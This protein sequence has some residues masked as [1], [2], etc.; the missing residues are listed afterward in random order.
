MCWLSPRSGKCW[1]ES[2][3][4]VNV[5][6]VAGASRRAQELP[7]TYPETL[8]QSPAACQ[9]CRPSPL[10]GPQQTPP[11][12]HMVRAGRYGRGACG[13]PYNCAKCFAHRS[14]IVISPIFPTIGVCH[15]II[16][17]FAPVIGTCVLMINVV[18][19]VCTF[20]MCVLSQSI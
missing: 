6:A 16:C 19:S 14:P 8:A 15:S 9:V 2:C 12:E 4:R 3:E 7:K 11:G 13:R 5:M 20:I 10:P 18:T 17:G 1:R